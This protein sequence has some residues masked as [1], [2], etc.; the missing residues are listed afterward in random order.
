MKMKGFF[1]LNSRISILNS[2][3]RKLCCSRC[4]KIGEKKP[5]LPISAAASS[6]ESAPAPAAVSAALAITIVP[7]WSVA[8][9]PGR[10]GSVNLDLLT[11]NGHSVQLGNGLVGTLLVSHGHEGV[12]LTR[13]VNILHY[14]TP[15]LQDDFHQDKMNVFEELH[16]IDMIAKAAIAT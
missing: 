3:F 2:R 7:A 15:I 5:D 1:F 11:I 8:S 9:L 4:R 10:L 12:T 16:H 13:I 14:A 6:S